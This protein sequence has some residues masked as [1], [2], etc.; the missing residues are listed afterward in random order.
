MTYRLILD[1]ALAATLEC[2]GVR[3]LWTLN[4]KDFAVFSFL[5]VV[6]PSQPA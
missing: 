4:L 1:T 5:R 2:A 3:Q 6:D